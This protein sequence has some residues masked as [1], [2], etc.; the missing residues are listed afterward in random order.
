MGFISNVGKTFLVSFVGSLAV[1]RSYLKYSGGVFLLWVGL[2]VYKNVTAVLKP[3]PSTPVPK[4]K[5]R[6]CVAAFTHSAPSANAHYM[7]DKL[8]KAHPEKYETWY[9][10]CAFSFFQFTAAKFA[11]VDFPQHLKG[12]ST[13]PF[14]WLEHPSATNENTIEPLGGSEHLREYAL[15]NS[16]NKEVQAFAKQDWKVSHYLTG[17]SYHCGAGALKPTA[18]GCVSASIW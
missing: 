3:H 2:I 6:I 14:C 9:Y 5:I 15:K 12:H 18:E 13:S 7:A 16:N 17:E 4:G 1:D 10:F 11:N 8:V